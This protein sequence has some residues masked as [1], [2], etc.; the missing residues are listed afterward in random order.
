MIGTLVSLSP[1]K[2]RGKDSCASVSTPER[3]MRTDALNSLWTVT[4]GE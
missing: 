3:D 2:S 4:R 1:K